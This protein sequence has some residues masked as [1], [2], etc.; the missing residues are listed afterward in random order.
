MALKDGRAREALRAAQLGERLA[1]D[2]GEDARVR[3]VLA[4]RAA[5]AWAALGDKGATNAAVGRA[6]TC[7]G[8]AGEESER[9]WAAFVN[10]EE[11]LTMHALCDSGLGDPKR[12]ATGLENAVAAAGPFLRNRASRAAHLAHAR[13]GA[14][15]LDGACQ[16]AE[17]AAKTVASSSRTR[18]VLAAFTQKLAG[19]DA[20]VA[21]QFVARWRAT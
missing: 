5:L 2:Q 9:R 21:R 16:A 19:H 1:T 20:P 12:A 11:L 17:D 13:L 15:D 7:L 8:Q 6:W 14:G 4:M 10:E 18:N 3:A